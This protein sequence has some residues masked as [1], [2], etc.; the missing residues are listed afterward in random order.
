MKVTEQI[1]IKLKYH[2]KASVTVI[3]DVSLKYLY[4]ATDAFIVRLYFII[5]TFDTLKKLSKT[6]EYNC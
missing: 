5:F 6:Y 2:F 4:S 3:F 1:K